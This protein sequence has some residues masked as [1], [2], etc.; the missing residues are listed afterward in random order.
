MAALARVRS[1]WSSLRDVTGP[2]VTGYSNSE[3]ATRYLLS[4]GEFSLHGFVELNDNHT[5]AAFTRLESAVREGSSPD[6]WAVGETSLQVAS[7]KGPP[8]SKKDGCVQDP[9]GPGERGDSERASVVGGT[10]GDGR[11]LAVSAAVAVQAPGVSGCAVPEKGAPGRGLT[12][13]R[14]YGHVSTLWPC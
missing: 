4:D 1:A 2:V 8:L 5:W 3:L 11:E 12:A 14:T 9:Q 10:A 7:P 13:C 6:Q